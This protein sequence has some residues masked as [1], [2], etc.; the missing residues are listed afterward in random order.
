MGECV[1]KQD[2]EMVSVTKRYGTTVAVQSVSYKFKADS[3]TCLLGPSGCG[4]SSTLR[5]IAGH[6]SV[7]EGSIVLSGRDIS[8]LPP[9]QRGTAMM[10]QNYALFPHLSVLD[11]V[12][13]SLKMKGDS[14]SDRHRSAGEILELVD[15]TELAN[16]MPDQLS[17]GQQQRVELTLRHDIGTNG[18]ELSHAAPDLAMA[19]PNEY[20]PLTLPQPQPHR[21]GGST[22]CGEEW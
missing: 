18:N 9:A 17:G 19:S 8:H 22:S 6:E 3:Y 13:F 12:A 20:H 14:K 1:N 21:M 4:K 10:F 7:S 2:L 5:M 16:R 15:L 11:N